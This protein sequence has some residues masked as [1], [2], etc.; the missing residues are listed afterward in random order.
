MP[1]RIG[2]EEGLALLFNS[3]WYLVFLPIVVTLFWVSPRFLRTP[4]LLIA[5]YIFY[6]SWKPIYGLLIFGMTLVN[7]F[8]GLGIAGAESPKRKKTLLVLAIAFNLILLAVFKYAYFTWDM[9][10][11]CAGWFAQHLPPMPWSIL[12]PLGISFFVFEFIHYVTDVY[13][14]GAPVRS[15]FQFALFASFFPTQIAGPI[16]RY[17]DFIPQLANDG[18]FGMDMLDKGLSLIIFGLFKKVVFADN[19]SVIVQSAFARP[20]LLSGVDL[21]LAVYAFAFQIYFDFSGY[22]DIARGSAW[23]MGYKVPPNFNL[24]YLATSITDFWHRWHISLSSWLRDYLFIPLGGSRGNQL[25]TW[26]NLML[27]MV[28]GGLWHGAAVHFILWGAYQGVMLIL[29]KLVK[30]W[31][32]S[33][34]WLANW[35]QT[36]L[37][38]SLSI[39]FT[40]HMV[41]IGWVF[42][43]ADT[44]DLS[45][46]IIRKLLFLDGFS[47]AASFAA[48]WHLSIVNTTEP[49]IFMLLP[50]IV[51]ALFIGQII[52]ARLG[53]L[54][55]Q[56]RLPSLMRGAYYAALVLLLLVFAPDTSPKFI[57]FQ[58]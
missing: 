31:S 28:L 34:V 6:C 42:F 49:V 3:F 12:L 40:F 51:A 58:F 32:D 26:R 16:K 36:S 10:G 15:F 54:V 24:P 20:D 21:W 33:I 45:M 8:L 17:Q 48:Q 38:R 19:L 56:P 4:I 50:F 18:K 11:I 46:Q 57:Y 2:R 5:S 30:N 13:K 41:C 52:C 9:A 55:T 1:S 35:K 39:V 23:L 43:R 22:T 14:G 37:F 7:F 44:F 29:H 53:S 25:F 27:T 47:S